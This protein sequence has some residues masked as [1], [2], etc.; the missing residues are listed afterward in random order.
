ML[1]FTAVNDSVR[2]STLS[3]LNKSSYSFCRLSPSHPPRVGLPTVIDP[4][5]ARTLIALSPAREAAITYLNCASISSGI[6]IVT[7]CP[8][9]RYLDLDSY[10]NKEKIHSDE[11]SSKLIEP[12]A[13][14]ELVS[15]TSA[16]VT[17]ITEKTLRPIFLEQPFI[18]L[19]APNQNLDLLKYGF[20][21]YDEIFDYSFDSQPNIEDRING[22]IENLNKIKDEDYYQ[23]Y[24]LLEPKIKRNKE[25]MFSLLENDPFNPYIDLYQK[26]IN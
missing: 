9:L 10:S 25:R 26:Y 14:I 3:P 4:G 8:F 17:F 23:L 13:L 7:I 12:N 5:F 11:Y 15:E 19:G 21:L 20:E 16:E 24:K 1:S 18:C 22:I 2:S 6:S